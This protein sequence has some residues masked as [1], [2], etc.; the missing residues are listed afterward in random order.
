VFQGQ[1]G[2]SRF[3]VDQEKIN[4]AKGSIFFILFC[5]PLFIAMVTKLLKTPLKSVIEHLRILIDAYIDLSF[6]PVEKDRG[7][8][9]GTK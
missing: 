6:L 2:K 1:K 9:K 4:A 7:V 5:C 3:V 8:L